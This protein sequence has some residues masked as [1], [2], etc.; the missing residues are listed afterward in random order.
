MNNYRIN[1]ID[2]HDLR[3]KSFETIAKDEESAL[4]NLWASYTNGNF[5][6]QIVEI[7]RLEEPAANGMRI[8]EAAA[9]IPFVKDHV[10]I[11]EGSMQ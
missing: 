9:L 8:G 1:Y 3:Y 11:S 7:I 5:D 4:S 6:H 10:G 2:G